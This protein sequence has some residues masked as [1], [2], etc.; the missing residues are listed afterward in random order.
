M[1]IYFVYY[2]VDLAKSE[3]AI[4]AIHAALADIERACGIRGRLMRRTDEPS[5]WMEVYDNVEDPASL[6]RAIEAAVAAHE[7]ERFLR[8]GTRRMFEKFEPHG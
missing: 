5:T 6:D 7:L 1:R 2:K 4:A 3:W 8:P